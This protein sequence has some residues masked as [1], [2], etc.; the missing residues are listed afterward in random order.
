MKEIGTVNIPAYQRKRS[1]AAK[2]R[3]KS[4]AEKLETTRKKAVRRTTTKQ[5]I[6][7]RQRFPE[8]M[9]IEDILSDIPAHEPVHTVD[10]FEEPELGYSSSTR[11]SGETREMK[12]VGRCDGYFEKIDVA[13]IK[14]T[15][16]LSVGDQ[17]I[18]QK[19]SGLFEQPVDSIQIDRQDVQVAHSGDDIGLKVIMK[20]KVGGLV[21]KVI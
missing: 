15:S 14:L 3:K 21:Y 16:P 8:E 2:A 17:V 7:S 11:P 20:P 13:V 5:I 19:L 18:F 1:L 6:T 9:L 4:T 12:L 10:E